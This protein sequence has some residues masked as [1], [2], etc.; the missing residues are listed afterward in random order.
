MFA[1]LGRGVETVTRANYFRKMAVGWRFAS[2]FLL[3]MAY[4][5]AFNW[6]NSYT[7][8]P[9]ISAFLKKYYPSTKGALFDIKDVKREWFEIDDSEYTNY[10]FDARHDYHSHH[11]PQPVSHFGF[12]V[13]GWRSQEYFLVR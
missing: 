5:R 2:V 9:L 8:G 4:K 11:G 6:Y 7:Y 12:R 10:T 3:G 13:L 1:G